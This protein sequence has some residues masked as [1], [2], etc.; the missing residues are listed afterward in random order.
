MLTD[1]SLVEHPP[2]V[3]LEFFGVQERKFRLGNRIIRADIEV[4]GKS[5]D[6]KGLEVEYNFATLPPPSIDV[7]G[8]LRA[9]LNAVTRYGAFLRRKAFVRVEIA[10]EEVWSEGLFTGFR[11]RDVTDGFVWLIC[12]SFYDEDDYRPVGWA[13]DG[14]EPPDARSRPDAEPLAE[15]DLLAHLVKD[16]AAV[17]LLLTIV[18]ARDKDAVAQPFTI[19][20]GRLGAILDIETVPPDAPSTVSQ[21][22]VYAEPNP[23]ATEPPLWVIDSPHGRV[24]QF[25]TRDEAIREALRLEAQRRRDRWTAKTLNFAQMYGSPGGIPQGQIVTFVS[26]TG[27]QAGKTYLDTLMVE[28]EA[29]KQGLL[30]GSA[31]KGLAGEALACCADIGLDPVQEDARPA[32]QHCQGSGST[33]DWKT[34]RKMKCPRCNGTGRVPE[35]QKGMRQRKAR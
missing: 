23:Q 18:K 1:F 5:H 17:P 30:D 21:F 3:A 8:T 35:V 27:R 2:E 29:I 33:R 19:S 15:E 9:D 20:P 32:C 14:R 24:A 16:S 26:P 13:C 22:V 34:H 25:P 12:G 4:T 10:R 6:L 31:L 28:Y 11:L 7:L